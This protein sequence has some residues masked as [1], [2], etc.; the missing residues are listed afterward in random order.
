MIRDVKHL[1]YTACPFIS[2]LRVVYASLMVRI[3]YLY[4]FGHLKMH[5]EKLYFGLVEFSK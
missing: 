3:L 5:Y 2:F 4:S 1:L